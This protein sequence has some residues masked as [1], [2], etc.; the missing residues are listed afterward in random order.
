MLHLCRTVAR[1]TING[2]I[3]LF[4]SLPFCCGQY[5]NMIRLVAIHHE[6]LLADTHLHL[7]KVSTKNGEEM[8]QNEKRT[9]EDRSTCRNHCLS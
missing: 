8:P 5:E 7:A 9:C 4:V 3:I 1:K 2:I 6:D